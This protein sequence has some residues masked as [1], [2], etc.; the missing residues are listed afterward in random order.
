[1]VNE[2]IMPF[3]QEKSSGLL[4]GLLMQFFHRFKLKAQLGSLAGG[5]TPQQLDVANH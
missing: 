5:F 4:Q 2:K 3:H 1:M